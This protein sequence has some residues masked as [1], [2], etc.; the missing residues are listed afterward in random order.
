MSWQTISQIV[1]LVGVL[2][3]AIG[4]FGSYYFGRTEQNER[5]RISDEKQ[6]ALREQIVQLQASTT[7]MS[8]QVQL[9]YQAAKLQEDVWIEVEMKNAPG[10]ITDYLMLLFTSDKGRISGKARIK[11]SEEIYTFSTT[12]N[13]KLSIA[14]RNVWI[15]SEGQYKSPIILQFVITQKTDPEA[16]FSIYTAGFIFSR[17]QEPH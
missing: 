11:G 7:R 14:L 1:L 17:G 15:E 4:G 10:P 13:N 3:T 12:V 8:E 2:L 16:S 6:A 9:I 5:E